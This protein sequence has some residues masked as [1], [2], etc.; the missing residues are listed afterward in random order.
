MNRNVSR[1]SKATF[2]LVALSA[3]AASGCRKEEPHEPPP[4]SRTVIAYMA[5][6]N[7]LS[8]DALVDMDEMVQGFI[9]TGATLVVLADVAGEAPYL[10]QIAETGR[11]KV[12]TY[13]EFNSAEADNLQNALN[14]IIEMYPAEH[15]GL[16]LW[17]HGA[18][19]MPAG[20]QLKSFVEDGG[21]QMNIIDLAAALPLRFDFILFDA[22]LMGAVEV[23]YELKDK[24]D[25]LIASSTETIYEGFPYDR[26]IPELLR[27]ETDLL[28]VAQS[29]FDYYDGLSGAFRSATIS[30]T[31][32]RRME[33]LAA[34]TALLIE[35]QPFDMTAF[36]RASVQRLDVYSEQYVFDFLDF[37]A[38][39]FPQTDRTA[40]REQL[41]ETVPYKA[42]T[43]QFLEKY[44]INTYCGLSCYVPHPLRN[45]LNVYYQQLSWCKTAGFFKL[46]KL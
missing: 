2:M 25:C 24:T 28:R 12:K 33:A 9:P 35:G 36:D 39:A 31:D 44:N 26:I 46:F 17:S 42:H 32:T 40:L 27:T 41:A 13:L 4:A 1:K 3:V 19:W 18:S 11:K 22:C 34:V 21:M 16:I 7:D 29:Y 5:A 10:L 8:G 14:E 43:S 30:V 23:A 38:K 20:R 37:T 6:D 45:D 15:Y